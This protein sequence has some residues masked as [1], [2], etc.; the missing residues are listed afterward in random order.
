MDVVLRLTMRLFDTRR[1]DTISID[2]NSFIIL[3]KMFLYLFGGSNLFGKAGDDMF[4]IRFA[5][6]AVSVD[7]V[8]VGVSWTGRLVI[9][10]SRL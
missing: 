1:L 2:S 7:L 5:A 3:T 10:F 6:G 8:V 9:Y 4:L